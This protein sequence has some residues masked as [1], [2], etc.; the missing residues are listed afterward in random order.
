MKKKL[1]IILTAIML[2]SIFG[3]CGNKQSSSGASSDV[4]K[5]TLLGAGYGDK[6]FWDS[7]KAGAEELEKA[8][9]GQVEVK[10]VDMTSDTKKWPTSMYEAGD[11]DADIIITGGF[12]QVDNVT[13]IAPEYPDK[14]WISFDTK[15]DYENNNLENTYSMGYQAN[16]SGYL[17]GMV[18]AY[19]TTSNNEGINEDKV[20]GFIGGMENTPIISD[21]LVGYIEGVKSVDP[22][23]KVVTAYT[24][25]FEDSA[26]AKEFAL[27]QFNS[28]NVDII[29]SVAG[30]SGTGCIEA[31]SN[32]GKYVIGV[33]SD[34]SLLY[35]GRPE[36]KVIVTSAL[37][38]VDTSIVYAVGQALKGELPFGSYESL[39]IKEGCIG[40]VYNDIFD[41]Y[42]DEAFKQE[43]MNAESKMA[44]GS[45]QVTSAFSMSN[46]EVKAL[47]D[48]VKP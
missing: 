13:E 27:A 7:A 36:Q 5:V 6:S 47:S 41:S 43:L 18:A 4:V 21:F 10:V 1:A 32:V 11:S 31:A 14:K 20:V 2:C 46:E 16:Q 30:A 29:F 28:D 15:L 40:L 23:I 42:V 44:D 8:Y 33:D 37:K 38:R 3:A 9:P 17:A 25:N 26:K 34:Q 45:I 24:N 12:Q 19:M 35:E 48:S 22:E 39:G